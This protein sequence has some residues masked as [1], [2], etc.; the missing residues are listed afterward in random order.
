MGDGMTELNETLGLTQHEAEALD[1]W[2]PPQAPLSMPPQ[3]LTREPSENPLLTW[4]RGFWLR[5][6]D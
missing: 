5:A 4:A 1:T 2:Q 3:A 6:S